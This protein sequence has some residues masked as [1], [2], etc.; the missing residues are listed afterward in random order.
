MKKFKSLIVAASLL[1][2]TIGVFAGRGKFTNYTLYAYDGSN[3]QQLETATFS[4]FPSGLSISTSNP[5]TITTSV[6][7]YT[8]HAND[9]LGTSA[10]NFSQIS[11]NGTW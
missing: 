5:I 1:L 8:L 3:F 9:G 11:S 10:S 4:S 2:L 6:R 7:S